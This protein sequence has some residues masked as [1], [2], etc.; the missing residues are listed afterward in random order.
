MNEPRARTW[1]RVAVL[2]PDAR[3]MMRGVNARPSPGAGTIVQTPT[4]GPRFA[5]HDGGEGQES[6][7]GQ[8]TSVVEVAC[9]VRPCCVPRR[10]GAEVRPPL[11]A[12]DEELLPRRD[13]TR[14]LW[15]LAP[16]AASST[17]GDVA[18]PV[19]RMIESTIGRDDLMGVATGCRG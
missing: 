10:P 18:G 7:V 1:T 8:W 13:C 19:M 14:I 16:V 9:G 12:V 6:H 11:S 3:K 2:V 15:M 5:S 4:A 17:T